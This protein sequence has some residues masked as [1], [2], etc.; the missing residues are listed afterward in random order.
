MG[1][2]TL[3]G[4]GHYI[5]GKGTTLWRGTLT[6]G[7][8]YRFMGRDTTSWEGHYIMEN[9]TTSW[10]GA[11][12]YHFFIGFYELP[13]ITFTTM[14]YSTFDSHELVIHRLHALSY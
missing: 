13:R 6:H 8:G 1:R 4:E 2:D 11:Q 3:H 10:G 7:E 9:G 14:S 5:M 12:H